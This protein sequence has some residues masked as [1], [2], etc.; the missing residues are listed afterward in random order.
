M[1][2]PLLRSIKCCTSN[3]SRN[4][5][6]KLALSTQLFKIKSCMCHRKLKRP[7]VYYFK[8]REREV[9]LVYKT[10]LAY[11]YMYRL[12]VWG[13]RMNISYNKTQLCITFNRGRKDWMHLDVLDYDTLSVFSFTFSIWPFSS[14]CQYIVVQNKWINSKKEVFYCIK[15]VIWS[16]A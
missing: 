16:C 6:L 10:H 14:Q 13:E 8:E 12:N 4:D 3:F 1:C 15:P 11:V 7:M 9:K 5:W 2:V